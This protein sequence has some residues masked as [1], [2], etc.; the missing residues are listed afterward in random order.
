[1]NLESQIYD[2][3]FIKFTH[4]CPTKKLSNLI[5]RILMK[6]HKQLFNV[7]FVVFEC[8]LSKCKNNMKLYILAIVLKLF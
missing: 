8:M 3:F 4:I 5:N 7:N 6:N 2:F 1:M